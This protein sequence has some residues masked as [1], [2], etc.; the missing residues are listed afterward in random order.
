MEESYIPRLKLNPGNNSPLIVFTPYADM[1]IVKWCNGSRIAFE[2]WWNAILSVFLMG[3]SYIPSLKLICE[4]ILYLSCSQ[5]IQTW[6]FLNY[7]TA[8]ILF[9][10][11]L[12]NAILSVVSIGGSYIQSLKL[13]R[14]FVFKL[15]CSQT[16]VKDGR[17]VAF[18]SQYNLKSNL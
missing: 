14:E 6:I 7:A 13:I 5:H 12:W 1:N 10:E 4:F 2:I 8:A 17:R 9:Q 15:A 3:P 16:F 11:I 18:L